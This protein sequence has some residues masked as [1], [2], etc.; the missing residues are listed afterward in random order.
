MSRIIFQGRGIRLCKTA[1]V[2]VRKVTETMRPPS[3]TSVDRSK[4]PLSAA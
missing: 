4:R 3:E 1:H 2:C